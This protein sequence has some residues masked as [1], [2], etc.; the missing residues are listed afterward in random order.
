MDLGGS[1][2]IEDE[3]IGVLTQWLRLFQAA[4]TRCD[5]DHIGGERGQE[6][7]TCRDSTP[8][9]VGQRKARRLFRCDEGQV[10]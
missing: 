6:K 2:P 3:A 10:R 1:V 5:W 8:P 7:E 9:S 4:T